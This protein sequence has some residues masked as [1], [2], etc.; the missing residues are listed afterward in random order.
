MPMALLLEQAP[1]FVPPPLPRKPERCYG[2]GD[3]PVSTSLRDGTWLC[4]S[5]LY[6]APLRED[7][8]LPHHDTVWES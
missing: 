5:C 7:G 6:R 1:P 4:R 8:R 2:G 3:K